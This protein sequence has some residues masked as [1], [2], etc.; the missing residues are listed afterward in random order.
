MNSLQEELKKNDYQNL[1]SQIYK[2]KN[3]S[4]N[5]INYKDLTYCIDK[6]EIA[7]R[8]NNIYQQ[9]KNII[10]DIDINNKIKSIVDNVNIPVELYFKFNQKI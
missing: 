6:L 5:N 7:K 8:Y 4:I 10:L 2:E 3:L 9:S 1:L